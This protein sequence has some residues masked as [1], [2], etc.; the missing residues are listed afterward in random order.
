MAA[1]GTIAAS[2]E[3]IDLMRDAHNEAIGQE[4]RQRATQCVGSL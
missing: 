3:Y 1:V 2:Q 4:S